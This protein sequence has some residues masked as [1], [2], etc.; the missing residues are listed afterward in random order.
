MPEEVAQRLDAA[1][2]RAA[3]D[4]RPAYQRNDDLGWIMHA[5]RDETCDKRPSRMTDERARGGLCMKRRW[6]GGR[7]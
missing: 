5:K 2:L 6:T 7:S 1:G 4:T 3:Y